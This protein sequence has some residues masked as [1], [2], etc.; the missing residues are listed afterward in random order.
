MKLYQPILFKLFHKD[1][2]FWKIYCFTDT[3]ERTAVATEHPPVNAE[4]APVNVEGAPVTDERIPGNAERASA[5][6]TRKM[7]A[8]SNDEGC[9]Q[10]Y[11]NMLLGVEPA[12]ED[13]LKN[14]EAPTAD[15]VSKGQK[16]SY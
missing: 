4:G 7:S 11:M 3:T 16:N 8:A 9:S 2:C 15:L 1:L 5:H 13:P 10:E 14:A 6:V 12:K